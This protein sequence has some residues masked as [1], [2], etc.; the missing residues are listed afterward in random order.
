MSPKFLD[1]AHEGKNEWWR[2]VLGVLLIVMLWLGVTMLLY[3]GL[4]IWVAVDHNPDTYF[5]ERT[6]SVAG[7]APFVHYIVLNLG[8]VAML[9][10]LCLAMRFLH[11]RPFLTLVTGA[12]TIRWGLL[13]RG[14]ALYFGLVALFT[15]VD[16]LL[17]PSIYRMTHNPLRVLVLAPVVLV[18]TPI[19]TTTEELMFRGYLLQA[20]G[21]V[22]QRFGFPAIL[23]S[24]LFTLLHL[25]NPEVAHGLLAVAAYYFGIGFFFCVVTIKSNSLELAI[26]AH[27]AVN[28]FA[29]LIVN[30]SDSALETESIF[31]CTTIDSLF[32]VTGFVFMAAIFYAL[33][34]GLKRAPEAGQ[35]V[36]S[37]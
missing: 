18:L 20:V 6:G 30:Y 31:F 7:L 16:F 25:T 11:K 17:N 19:Q 12:P 10:G 23:S 2:Y 27:S 8:H 35:H 28:L 24:L 15:F 26:G 9:V 36:G 14:F 1:L 5:D 21:L 22:S 13:V 37:L 32:V 33:A 3:A 4:G 29:A 34:F